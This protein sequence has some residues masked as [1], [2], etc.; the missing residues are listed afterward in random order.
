MTKRYYDLH[1]FLSRSSGYSVPIEI[2]SVKVL[3]EDEIIQYAIDNNLIDSDDSDMIDY[4]VEIDYSEY[5][6]M[7]GI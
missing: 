2:E 5:E 3:S 1:V 4:V 7:Q 6:L